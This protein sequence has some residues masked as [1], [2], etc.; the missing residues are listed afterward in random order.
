MILQKPNKNSVLCVPLG[1][2]GQF[3]ANFTLYG[4]NGSWIAV[5]CGMGFA[6]E[7]M[8]GVDI[9]LPD[10]SAIA[11]QKE[12]LK[13]LFVTHA[14]EDHIGG[15]AYLWP[16]LQCPIYATPFTAMLLRKK[17][18]EHQYKKKPKIV[19]VEP[20]AMVEIEGW[21][22]EYASVTHSVPE[23][24]ALFIRTDVG[25][26]VHSG[27]WN[28][29][30]APTLGAATDPAPFIAAGKEGVMAYVGDST[31]ADVRARPLTESDVEKGLEEVFKTCK[32]RIAITIFASNVGRIIAIY[33]AARACGRH[34][35][36]SGRSL[37]T[38]VGVARETGYIP[39]DMQFVD[40]RDAM[41]MPDNK[42]V[43]IVTGSQGEGRAA[44]S[45]IARGA[46]PAVKL[47]PNDTVIF[48]SRAIP[49]NEVAIN[50]I[51][52]L[53]LA[54]GVKIITDR[55]G[56]IHVSGHPTRPE[57][58]QMLDWLKPNAVIPVHGERMQMEAQASL[59]QEKQIAHTLVPSNGMVIA[60]SPEGV[61]TIDNVPCGVKAVDMDRIVA[62][63]HLPILERRKMS[64]NGAV[65]V[66]VVADR[67]DGTLLEMRVSALGLLDS[68]REEDNNTLAEIEDLLADRFEEL[69]RQ[70]RLNEAT[71]IETL[72]AASRKYFREY[73]DIKPLVDIHYMA[74]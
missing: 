8:P 20:D 39:K 49:G 50:E 67:Q 54:T 36:L 30:P 60:I 68:A 17:M 37:Q 4:H 27:D 32:R 3:G 33:K 61:K 43:L 63:D 45:K 9:L 46:H 58:E 7:R 15:I 66:S 64:F 26:I 18:E 47:R 25:L 56:P 34:V 16:Q 73:G 69:G 70:D 71:S 5:D 21:S 19:V 40:D 11:E 28:L 24:N 38:M 72:R 2:C 48:S 42:V 22:V 65:F 41:E 59:A 35:A 14:H 13:A 57:I 51:K 10:I 62:A 74:V 6:D 12:N 55:D 44:L 52:N 53:L 29:D 23:T 1:G 31:N